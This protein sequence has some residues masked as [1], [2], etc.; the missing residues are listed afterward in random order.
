[1]IECERCGK[2]RKTE[3][4]PD[5]WLGQ[6]LLGYY[7]GFL[8]MWDKSIERSELA[9]QMEDPS[10]WPYFHIAEPFSAIG[11]Y[12]KA[13]EFLENYRDKYGNHYQIALTFANIYLCQG[14]Y[15]LA[16]MENDFAYS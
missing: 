1:M 13:I 12:D 2:Q 8:E 11:L 15:D 10:F 7:Y 16:L 5:D 3:L 14:K 6:A 4:Y 9:I